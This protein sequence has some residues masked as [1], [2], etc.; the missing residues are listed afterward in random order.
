LCTRKHLFAGIEFDAGGKLESWR[1]T[2]ADPS[3][4]THHIKTLLVGSLQFV[5]TADTEPARTGWLDHGFPTQTRCRILTGT[6]H[7]RYSTPLS[8]SYTM[9]RRH[10]SSASSSRN[11]GFHAPEDTCSPISSS[12][13]QATSARGR[14]RSRM[15]R[16]PLKALG[17][18]TVLLQHIRPS[19]VL[20]STIP[21]L[22]LH[23]RPN[24]RISRSNH[25]SK[26]NFG[27]RSRVHKRQRIP[28]R[29]RC[30]GPDFDVEAVMHLVDPTDWRQ[31][32]K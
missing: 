3:T 28:V 17:M 29:R 2:F 20:K 27:G 24:T 13:P 4:S 23:G 18:Q 26:S 15:L 7:Q 8:T 19:G 21:L 6:S 5:T 30:W 31:R 25:E 14:R 32:V 22:F 10:S 11:H 9:N 1:E 12:V 16:T